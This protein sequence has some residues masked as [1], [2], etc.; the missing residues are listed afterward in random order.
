MC[1]GRP[2][3]R[4]P[5]LDAAEFKPGRWSKR[6]VGAERWVRPSLVVEVAFGEWTAD[7]RIRHA[8]FRGIRTD[9]PAKMIVRERVK[10]PAAPALAPVAPESKAARTISKVNI[11]HPDRVIDPT[12]GLRKIDLVR[13]YESVAEWMLPHLKD[14]PAS[15][16]RAPTGITGQLFF[17]KHPESKMPGL[18]E[19]DP[20]RPANAAGAFPGHP[21]CAGR[22]GTA[23]R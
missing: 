12:T 20:P 5:P 21:R 10:N 19:L 16:V 22:S 6:K 14:R 9:K 1:W 7:K 13:Y 23:R 15:L 11:T 18:K 17:Q 3:S 4:P 8:V 2:K